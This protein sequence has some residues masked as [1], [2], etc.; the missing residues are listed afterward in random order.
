MCIPLKL[1]DFDH[2]VVKIN[3]NLQKNCS[4]HLPDTNFSRA[5]NCLKKGI[6]SFMNNGYLYLIPIFWKAERNVEPRPACNFE[7]M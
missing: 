2:K 4:E 6:N 3:L 1:P 5:I 7:S